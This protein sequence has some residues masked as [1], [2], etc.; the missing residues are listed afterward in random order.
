MYKPGLAVLLASS[1]ALAAP[2]ASPATYDDKSMARLAGEVLATYRD[3]DR[4]TYLDNLFRLQLAAGRAGDAAK[5][6]GELRTARE[7]AKHPAD[8]LF[9]FEVEAAA[10]VDTAHKYPLAYAR[11]FRAALTR[12]DDLAAFQAL[13]PLYT[14]AS[15]FD[16]DLHATE[17]RAKT[18]PTLTI[19]DA[20]ELIR[21]YQEVALRQR[22]E[23]VVTPLLA[24]DDARRYVVDTNV[25][26]KTRDGVTI[27]T[28]VFRPRAPAKSTSLFSFTIYARDEWSTAEARRAAAH[29]YAGVVAYTRGKGRSPDQPVPYEHDGDD[30]TAVIEWIS[31]QPWSD[32]RVGMFG[33]SYAGFTQWAA[34]KKLPPALKAIMPS[35]TAAPGIDVPMEGSAW[36]SFVYPWPIYAAGGHA[37]DDAHYNDHARWDRLN[38][39]WYTTGQ[40]YRA[41]DRIDGQPNPFYQRWLEHPAYDRYWQAMIPYQR[42]FANINI[43][44][45]T[46]TG[47]YD[48]GQI[49]ALYYF[50][51]HHDFNAHADHSFLIGPYEHLTGQRRVLDVLTNYPIDAVARID[52][53]TVRFAWFDYIFKGAPKPEIVSGVVNYEVMGANEWKHAPSLAAMSN[54]KLRLYLAHPGDLLPKADPHAFKQRI[55]FA[56]RSDVDWDPASDIITKQP[57]AHDGIVFASAPF[58][59]PVEL[60]GLFSGTLDFVTNK[61]DFDVN[62]SLYEQLPSGEYFQLSYWLARASYVRDRSVRHLLTPGTRQQL[63]FTAGRMTSRK[64]SAGSRVVVVLS[65]P[66]E[67]DQQINYGTGNEVADETIADAKQ[68]LQVDWYGTSFLDIPLWR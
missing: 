25:L 16:D 39:T 60:S 9:A 23:A 24:E 19:A 7:A 65:I 15:A 59:Q 3:A 52:I 22:W 42:E 20:V 49:G 10:E 26:I 36:L 57:D 31:Q 12:L 50:M 28:M 40:A 44:V 68:P 41:L 53:R 2:P 56:D 17:A 6:L 33:G 32:G 29:G 14:P 35:M 55:D 67:R 62:I 27:A 45:L 1:S 11:V 37:D 66:K 21:R 5:S 46:T 38:R 63:V 13:S 30:A 51:A 4:E 43:P 58:T 64:L 8:N 47:Y 48:G 54:S 18:K 34:A 61:R